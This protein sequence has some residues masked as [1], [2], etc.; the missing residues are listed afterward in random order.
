MSATRPWVDAFADDMEAKLAENRHK[1]DRAGWAECDALWLLSRLM[2]EV[3][4]LTDVLGDEGLADRRHCIRR[5][6]AD[7]ANFAMMISDVAG[8]MKPQE[9]SDGR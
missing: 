1:G 6:C 7:V 5:E 9:P 8:G 4:E 3:A 2:R